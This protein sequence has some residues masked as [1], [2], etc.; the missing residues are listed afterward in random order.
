MRASNAFSGL[1]CDEAP[2]LF[3]EF[4]GPTERNVIEQA[5]IA[6]E[7][8]RDNGVSSFRFSTRP[9]ERSRLWKA[10]HEAYY[11]TLA[12]RPG[13]KGWA[14]DVCVPISRLTEAIVAAKQELDSSSLT[15]T[16]VGHLG[17]GNFHMVYLMDPESPAERQEARR[18]NDLLVR[19]ALEVG[20]TC[21]GEVIGYR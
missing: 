17:D 6:Q 15:G 5:E 11:A 7:L 18:L 3:F 1:A 21:T 14:T 9:E 10:R 19:R 16:V 20:G 8:A 12:T 13:A 4:H 2:T